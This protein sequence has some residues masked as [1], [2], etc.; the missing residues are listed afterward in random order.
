MGGAYVGMAGL[1][2][3][4]IGGNVTHE[5]LS[6]VYLR[7]KDLKSFMVRRFLAL[8]VCDLGCM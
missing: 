5:C 1:L 4:V 7:A 6:L 8:Q 3:L 2:S